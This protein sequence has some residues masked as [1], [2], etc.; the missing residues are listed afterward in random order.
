MLIPIN[1][2]A[3][4]GIAVHIK[5]LREPGMLA[6]CHSPWNTAYPMVSNPCTLLSLL[7]SSHQVYTV[8]D[9]KDAFFSLPLAEVS[10]PT[11]ALEWTDLEEGFS[12]QLTWTRLPHGFKNSPTLFDEALSHDLI[13]FRAEHPESSTRPD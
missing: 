13:A 10:Q 12:G 8:L 9:L 3:K 1:V 4:R 11:F 5:R 7:P 2:E 6:P